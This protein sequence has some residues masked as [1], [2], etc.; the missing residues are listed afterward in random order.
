M[1]TITGGD[2]TQRSIVADTIAAYAGGANVRS[3]TLN[4]SGHL[5]QTYACT[6]PSDIALNIAAMGHNSTQIKMVLVHEIMH[7]MQNTVYPCLYNTPQVYNQ[8]GGFEPMT[9][10]MTAAI[11][12]STAYL[13]YQTHF[14][15]NQLHLASLVA[16]GTR[17]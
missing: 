12:G 15:P 16:H 8:F 9:D 13:N 6:T 11:T 5:G 10:A 7:A 14:T 1:T 17:I 3:V 4:S 2:Q